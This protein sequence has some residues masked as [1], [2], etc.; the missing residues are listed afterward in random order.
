VLLAVQ[1]IIS[2]D[3]MEVLDISRLL[4]GV[5]D[6]KEGS[7][8]GGESKAVITA[9]S[10]S[11]STVP[12]DEMEV[13]DISLPGDGAVAEQQTKKGPWD[14]AEVD[15]QQQIEKGK[16]KQ[17]T[18]PLAMTMAFK[19]GDGVRTSSS[20]PESD[21]F[22]PSVY[23][24]G[25]GSKVSASTTMIATSLPLPLSSSPPNSKSKFPTSFRARGCCSHHHHPDFA[26]RIIDCSFGGFRPDSDDSNVIPPS[27]SSDTA[28]SPSSTSIPPHPQTQVP[29]TPQTVVPVIVVG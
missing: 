29:A 10:G 14:G 28:T 6:D 24:P 8:D 20:L 26:H 27:S 22:F 9:H 21:R 15:K 3:A 4:G 7:P 18:P 19:S 17:E 5:D 25:D 16:R 23:S 1:S 12:F 11:L 13:L 2:F